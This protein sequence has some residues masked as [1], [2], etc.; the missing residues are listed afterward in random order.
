MLSGAY[1][2]AAMANHAVLVP[3]ELLRQLAALLHAQADEN[4]EVQLEQSEAE[5]EV[6]RTKAA[7]EEEVARTRAAARAEWERAGEGLRSLILGAAGE[8]ARLRGARGDGAADP[9]VE[10][11]QSEHQQQQS[12]QQQALP[13]DARERALAQQE[14]A[15]AARAAELSAREAAVDARERELGLH[16]QR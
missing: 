15:L 1:D 2:G 3:V 7:K 4:S 13:A 10:G 12:Q 14:A 8:M 6:A 5:K 9:S 11:R 16:P